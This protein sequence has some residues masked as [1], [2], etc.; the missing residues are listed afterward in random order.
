MV[1][2]DL[3]HISGKEATLKNYQYIFYWNPLVTDYV[4]TLNQPKPNYVCMRQ[5]WYLT[6]TWRVPQLNQYSRNLLCR[7][8]K[9]RYDSL[10]LFFQDQSIAP[11][12]GLFPRYKNFHSEDK[13]GIKPLYLYNEKSY[14]I[15][16]IVMHWN[17]SC[18]L[19][20]A[21][22]HSQWNKASLNIDKSKKNYGWGV[23]F[24]PNLFLKWL[25]VE[26][27]N[28]IHQQCFQVTTS[29]NRLITSESHRREKT[30]SKQC[31]LKYN[32]SHNSIRPKCDGQSKIAQ[33]IDL[34]QFRWSTW[35]TAIV[36]KY[37]M[38]YF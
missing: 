36:V 26:M 27:L 30:T 28:K 31:W 38:I 4:S 9:G 22:V 15:K 2:K 10:V 13:T 29:D 25:C 19:S 37:N 34:I 33:E 24:R 16:N 14:T 5:V 11:I 7:R 32:G 21:D 20:M 3:T 23:N 12:W 17:S 18:F 8:L 6:N 1:P 35:P